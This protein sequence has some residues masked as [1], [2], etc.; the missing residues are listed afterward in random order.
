MS[1]LNHE[2]G[3][4]K[5]QH[6]LVHFRVD[7]NLISFEIAASEPNTAYQIAVGDRILARMLDAMCSFA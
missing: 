5:H 4:H 6:N 1:L 2:G 7:L 3:S